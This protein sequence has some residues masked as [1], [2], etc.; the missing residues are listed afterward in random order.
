MGAMVGGLV[1]KRSSGLVC[2]SAGCAAGDVRPGA[3]VALDAKRS[4]P[5]KSFAAL[6]KQ[7]KRVLL[8]YDN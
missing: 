4:E 5:N 8:G 3:S 1:L 7:E 2:T 6:W